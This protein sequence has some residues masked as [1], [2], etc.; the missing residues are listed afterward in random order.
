MRLK[1]ILFPVFVIIP[2]MAISSIAIGEQTEFWKDKSEAKIQLAAA[3]TAEQAFYGDFG[4]YHTCLKYMGYDPGGEAENR[5]YA[6][7]FVNKHGNIDSKNYQ[8]AVLSGLDTR[9]C[10]NNLKPNGAE[11][12][13][14]TNK[15]L[16][17]PFEDTRI[18]SNTYFLSSNK[19]RKRNVIGDSVFQNFIQKTEL[20]NE[21]GEKI[22]INNNVE[23]TDFNISDKS[24]TEGLGKQGSAGEQHFIIP[25][26]GRIGFDSNRQI[27]VFTINTKKEIVD[28]MP[29]L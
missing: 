25:A 8:N 23:L 15:E 18:G 10:P 14:V 9:L 6:I 4:I 2:P 1:N 24:I 16:G 22:I 5:N 19:K 27:S 11:I 17:H 20:K 3:Y 29:N 28:H 26:A 13:V 7:G 21:K 12:D